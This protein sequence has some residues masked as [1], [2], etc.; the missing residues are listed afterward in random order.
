MRRI[1]ERKDEVGVK[2]KNSKDSDLEYG[3]PI[4]RHKNVDIEESGHL[5]N[6]IV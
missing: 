2:E 3:R 5:T 6:G 4:V 1:T